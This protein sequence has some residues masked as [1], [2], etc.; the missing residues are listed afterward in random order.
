[1]PTAACEFIFGVG[2]IG[3]GGK[4]S[5]PTKAKKIMSNWSELKNN[6]RLRAI[7]DDRIAITRA[8]REFFWSKGFAETETPCAVRL[9]GQEPYLNPVPVTAHDTAGAEYKFYLHTSPE[10]AMKKLLA[11]GYDKIFQIARCWRDCESFGGAHNPE[12][13]MIEWYRT[14]GD[15]PAIMDDT[16]ALFKFV[17]EKLGK[18]EVAYRGQ[19]VAIDGVWERMSMKEVWQKYAGV[20]LDEFLETE[21]LRELARARGHAADTGDA[22]EDIFYKIFLNEVEPKL[23]A[24]KPVFVYDY[25][26]RMCS[27]SRLCADARYAE[28]F[29]LYIAGLEVANAFG[30]LADPAAQKRN[31]GADRERRAALGKDTWPVDPDFIAALAA[32]MGEAGGIA[33][34]L[35]R[36]VLLFTAARDINEVI[37]QSIKDQINT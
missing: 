20:N 14:P 5:S 12:F 33:L 28:R 13:T 37:F 16:E 21:K 15:C 25:P 35:D 34:G 29:E 32:G 30:E 17:G 24:E 23:G 36:M 6:P 26:A 19:T 7:Y 10:F 1:M 3:R 22:Y 8:A 27:L 18:K 11:A 4:K 9:P 2:F 31:L